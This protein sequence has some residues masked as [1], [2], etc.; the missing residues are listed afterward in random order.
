MKAREAAEATAV[1]SQ[2]VV[3]QERDRRGQLVILDKKIAPDDIKHHQFEQKMLEREIGQ[4]DTVLEV[5]KKDKGFH[6][7]K[8]AIVDDAPEKDERWTSAGYNEGSY[9]SQKEDGEWDAPERATH[10]L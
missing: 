7:E 5:I 9:G 2:F 4:R 10:Q 8:S 6:K 3:D 1:L